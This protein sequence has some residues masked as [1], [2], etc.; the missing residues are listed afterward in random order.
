MNRIDRIHFEESARMFVGV[1]DAVRPLPTLAFKYSILERHDI[2]SVIAMEA[3]PRYREV[4]S[5]RRLSQ[6]AQ[7]A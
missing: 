6:M 5:R 3:T 7:I 4:G 1:V 2:D